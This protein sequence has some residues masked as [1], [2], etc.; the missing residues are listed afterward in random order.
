MSLAEWAWHRIQEDRPIADALDDEIREAGHLNE[1]ISVFKLGII[2][3]G[4]LPS[5]RPSMKEVLQILKQCSGSFGSPL[6][7]SRDEYAAAP[8]LRSQKLQ[9]QASTGRLR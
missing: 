4:I 8:L 3:T 2:C 1:M 5:T 6:Q 7:K 9:A